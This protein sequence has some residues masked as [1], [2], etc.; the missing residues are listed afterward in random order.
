MYQHYSD[1]STRQLQPFDTYNAHIL[2]P[3]TSLPIPYKE[4]GYLPQAQWN[5]YNSMSALD[6]LGQIQ[7]LNKFP[8]FT[9]VLL[10]QTEMTGASFRPY[11]DQHNQNSAEVLRY[12][13][14]SPQGINQIV[15]S[16]QS[17]LTADYEH[18]LQGNIPGVTGAKVGQY[19]EE[20]TYCPIVPTHAHSATPISKK[21]VGDYG[22]IHMEK[23]KE[24]GLKMPKWTSA[25]GTSL[26]HIQN[27]QQTQF[28]FGSRSLQNR[29]QKI[30]LPTKSTPLPVNVRTNH[31]YRHHT[32]HG[33]NRNK[34]QLVKEKR[35]THTPG[36][37]G[38]ANSTR[39]GPNSHMR[40]GESKRHPPPNMMQPQIY[41]GEN[42]R[43]KGSN[44]QQLGPPV[45]H[46]STGQSGINFSNFISKSKTP[47][48]S[49]FTNLE[50]SNMTAANEVTGLGP[51]LSDTGTH[52]KVATLNGTA[53]ATSMNKGPVNQLHFYLEE[54]HNQWK[55]LEMD[56]ELVSFNVIPD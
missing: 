3:P 38:E 35:R 48:R 45:F 11:D 43:V 27:F 1:T 7:Q 15:N 39:N 32:Q 29:Q 44:T 34:P 21:M 52:S 47:H 18:L 24:V 19:Q 16:F 13:P 49:S 26:P 56:T 5:R 23:D 31:H 40:G 55:L 20:K 36:F 14:H 2:H 17:L 8:G 33:Q 9:E 4:S 46:G 10:P 28:H 41:A 53:L 25:G 6:N 51:V 30:L 37:Q 12:E 54:C 22:K 42:E 50:T